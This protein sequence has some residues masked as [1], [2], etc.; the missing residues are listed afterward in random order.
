MKWNA[1]AHVWKQTVLTAEQEDQAV[2]ELNERMQETRQRLRAQLLA[3]QAARDREN[4]TTG[5]TDAAT[6]D[7]DVLNVSDMPADEPTGECGDAMGTT[8]GASDSQLQPEEGTLWVITVIETVSVCCKY[9]VRGCDCSTVVWQNQVFT[10]LSLAAVL[11]ML[12]LCSGF[13]TALLSALFR[14]LPLTCVGFRRCLCRLIAGKWHAL[15]CT[16]WLLLQMKEIPT[17]RQNAKL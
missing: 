15:G 7:G 12:P 8:A 5:N 4:Q 9:T 14:T 13:T 11:R 1:A 10:M 17:D 6:S 2:R 3:Q 16:K